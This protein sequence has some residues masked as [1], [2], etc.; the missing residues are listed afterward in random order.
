M[1][2]GTTLFR[3]SKSG[4][5]FTGPDIEYGA[6]T[7]SQPLQCLKCGSIRT[8]PWSLSAIFGLKQKEYKLIWEQMEKGKK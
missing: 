8:Y 4:H 1:V 7:Y 6:M 3:C 2:R 5:F